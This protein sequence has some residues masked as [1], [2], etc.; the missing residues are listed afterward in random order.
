MQNVGEKKAG[1]RGTIYVVKERRNHSTKR[2][3]SPTFAEKKH[4]SRGKANHP[5]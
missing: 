5:Q 3:L 4:Q 2:K 1:L